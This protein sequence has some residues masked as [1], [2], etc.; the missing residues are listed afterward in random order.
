ML[1]NVVISIFRFGLMFLLLLIQVTTG[2]S[3]ASSPISDVQGDIIYYSDYLSAHHKNLFANVSKERFDSA[4][5][6]L[7][8]RAD[9]L[10]P[11]KL[12]VELFKINALVADEHTRI[13][14]LSTLRLPL[15]LNILMMELLLL[16]PTG[17]TKI[18]C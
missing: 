3:Q 13:D 4:I 6:A 9:Y 12:I 10:S 15:V 7:K 16:P 1:F 5:T 14:L 11:E 2:L 8:N 18:Y 17:N